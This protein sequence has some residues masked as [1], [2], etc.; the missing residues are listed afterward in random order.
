MKTRRQIL[1]VLVIVEMALAGIAS[2]AQQVISWGMTFLGE[3]TTNT[4]PGLSNVVAVETVPA[5]NMVLFTNGTVTAW[6]DDAQGQLEAIGQLTNLASISG[7]FSDVLGLT[8]DGTVEV[9]AWGNNPGRFTNVPPNLTNVVA[10][11]AGGSHSLALLRDGTVLAWGE[12]VPGT[13]FVLPPG[14]SNVVDVQATLIGG[15][16]LKADGTV[17]ALGDG[18]VTPPV[19]GLSNIVAISTA[20]AE[21]F[22]A[23]R[24]DGSVVT[25]TGRNGIAGFRDPLPAPADPTPLLAINMEHYHSLGIAQDGTLRAWRL[26]PGVVP[27]PEPYLQIPPEAASGVIAFAAGREANVALVGEFGWPWIRTQP[28]NITTTDGQ[29]VTFEAKAEAVLPFHFQWYFK[30]INLLGETNA[31]LT[32]SNVD[33]T[34][35]GPYGVVVWTDVR[36]VRSQPAW[37]TVVPMIQVEGVGSQVK[38]SW[39]MSGAE[40]RLEEANDMTQP[41]RA[42]FEN[43]V[44]NQLTGKIE[45][46]L[47][48]SGQARFFRLWLP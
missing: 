28:E 17:T 8:R 30:G 29:S 15:L 26:R 31:T 46:A 25:W 45:V 38:L 5:L 2:G 34:K 13:P 18:F 42:A 36:R 10:L 24:S 35:A 4:P 32:V 7:G 20:Y 41:F 23:L 43:I 9:A 1:L 40:Y 11:A 33:V 14:L 48:P 6:G 47:N 44:T 3:T 39:P 27:P 19:P 22:M 21:D 37:L 12:S 16:V